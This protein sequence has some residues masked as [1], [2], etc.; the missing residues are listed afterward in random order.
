MHLRTYVGHYVRVY[1][2]REMRE[3]FNGQCEGCNSWSHDPFCSKCGRRVVKKTR[4]VQISLWDI[5]QRLDLDEDLFT[6]TSETQF[7]DYVIALPNGWDNGPDLPA[8]YDGG[9]GGEIDLTPWPLEEQWHTLTGA[10][11]VAG[12]KYE[13]RFGIVRYWS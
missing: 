6:S 9:D 4:E 13:T 8:E 5:I 12:I 2:G 11:T 10:L 1:S 3:D 7:P